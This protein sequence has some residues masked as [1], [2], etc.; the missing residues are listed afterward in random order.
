M[1]AHGA[2]LL[3]IAEA[4]TGIPGKYVEIEKTVNAFKELLAGQYDDLPEQAFYFV[5]DIEEAVT[6]AHTNLL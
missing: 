6:K 4:Y 2:P 1:V 5:G 3:N